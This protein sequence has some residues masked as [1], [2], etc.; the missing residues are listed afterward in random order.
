[1]TSPNAP[2]SIASTNAR[3]RCAAR[4]G[5]IDVLGRA[6][7]ALGDMGR[8]PALARIDDLAGE[9]GVARAGEARSPRRAATKRSISAWS[10]WVFDQSK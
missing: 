9:Q 3:I 5:E 10:R 6:A 8:R 1:M 4:G 7:A 2:A